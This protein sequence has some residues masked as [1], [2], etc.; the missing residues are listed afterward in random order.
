MYMHFFPHTLFH[1]VLSQELEYSLLCCTVCPHCLCIQLHNTKTNNPVETWAE[2]LNRHVSKGDIRL[3]NRHMKRGSTSLII[4]EMQIKTTRR[5]RG[6]F[7]FVACFLS[8]FYGLIHSIWKFLGQELNPSHSCSVACSAKSFSPLHWAGD[9][10]HTSTATQ[11]T[12]VRLLTPCAMA[13]PP[14]MHSLTLL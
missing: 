13:G 3:A 4:R 11:A 14:K 6:L 9:W 7:S 8:Q 5:Y 2:D 10:T 12:A 1:R